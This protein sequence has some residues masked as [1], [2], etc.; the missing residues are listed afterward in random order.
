MI[1]ALADDSLFYSVAGF[2]WEKPE[3][4]IH[5]CAPVNTHARNTRTD[6]A[7][8]LMEFWRNEAFL[9]VGIS[10]PNLILPYLH[11]PQSTVF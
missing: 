4:E 5:G 11:I 8:R 3:V 2:Y 9:K 6:R 7:S 1:K 10:C